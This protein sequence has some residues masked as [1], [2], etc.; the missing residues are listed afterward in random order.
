[1]KTPADL[2]T[3]EF[4]EYLLTEIPRRLPAP[5][6]HPGTR[7]ANRFSHRAAYRQLMRE[8]ILAKL[9]DPQ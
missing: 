4:F 7:V 6:E 5:S 2:L 9:A 3:D 8:L 1:M